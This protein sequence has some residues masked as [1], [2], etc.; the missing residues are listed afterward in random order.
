MEYA[1][2]EGTLKV[3]MYL[4]HSFMME[5]EPGAVRHYCVQ[6]VMLYLEMLF[7]WYNAPDQRVIIKLL[8]VHS[9][10][11]KHHSIF[12]MFTVAWMGL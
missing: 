3:F 8:Q 2:E 7:I 5:S 10:R 4:N 11:I 1:K 9:N 6:R 12:E